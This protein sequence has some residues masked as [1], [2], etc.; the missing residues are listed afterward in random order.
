M[1][2]SGRWHQRGL[3]LLELLVAFAILAT[4]LGMLYKASGD[5]LF[6]YDRDH[7]QARKNLKKDILY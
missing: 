2:R 7:A 3:S 1:S 4:A 6:D 5:L